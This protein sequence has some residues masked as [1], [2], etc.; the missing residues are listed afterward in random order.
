MAKRALLFLL[1]VLP[2]AAAV[3]T[4]GYYLFLDWS[5]LIS[6]FARFEKAV[7]SGADLRTLYVYGTLDGVYR[8]NAFADGVGVMLGA[9]LL[10]IGVHGMCVLRPAPATQPQVVPAPRG[11]RPLVPTGLAL[12]AVFATGGVLLA[13]VQ[14]VGQT[15]DLRR[16]VIR[17]DAQRVEWMVRRGV[18]P[19][20]RLWWR[21]SALDTARKE[22][23][24]GH[25]IRS[26]LEAGYQR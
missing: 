24:P 13:L 8:I 21:E 19:R 7:Q 6:A 15:N 17:E 3:V 5:A 11:P 26:V 22:L 1:V 16:A 20:D 14:R 9:I 4:C 23:H 25:R 10:G 2:G 12:L 18:D